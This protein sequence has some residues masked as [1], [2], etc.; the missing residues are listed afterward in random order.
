MHETTYEIAPLNLP[1]E[2]SNIQVAETSKDVGAFEMG[3]ASLNLEILSGN[4]VIKLFCMLH[5]CIVQ[6]YK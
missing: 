5:Y 3:S 1:S 6:F 4:L 2:A